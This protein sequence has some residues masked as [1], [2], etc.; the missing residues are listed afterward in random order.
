MKKLIFLPILFL[1]ACNSSTESGLSPNQNV[2]LTALDQ[3]PFSSEL[4]WV[5]SS[6]ECGIIN[7]APDKKIFGQAYYY[8][9]NLDEDNYYPFITAKYENLNSTYW[10]EA[11]GLDSID[12]TNFMKENFESPKNEIRIPHTV[13]IDG[14]TYEAEFQ[15][16][17]SFGQWIE[18]FQTNY[19]SAWQADYLYVIYFE[20]EPCSVRGLGFTSF[21]DI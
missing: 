20:D 1:V 6:D 12:M 16:K 14:V 17:G 10:T 4:V 7:N 21:I 2:G 5:D 8:E 15:I 18:S 9:E 13:V 19:G 11:F 3:E